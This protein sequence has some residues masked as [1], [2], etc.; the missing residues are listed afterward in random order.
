MSEKTQKKIRLEQ[1]YH[2][3]L[4]NFRAALEEEPFDES[5]FTDHNRYQNYLQDIPQIEFRLH[6]LARKN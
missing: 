2:P 1:I 6:L 5:A 3:V 4:R